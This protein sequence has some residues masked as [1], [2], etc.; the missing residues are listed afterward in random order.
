VA[1]EPVRYPDELPRSVQCC[2]LDGTGRDPTLRK[3][4]EEDPHTDWPMFAVRLPPRPGEA[5]AG[6]GALPRPR[7][8]GEGSVFLVDDA[9]P[10]VTMQEAEAAEELGEEV[11]A[12]V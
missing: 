10:T 9:I 12:S 7:L 11:R 4:R 1:L 2:P 3:C 6:A 8:S 5:E